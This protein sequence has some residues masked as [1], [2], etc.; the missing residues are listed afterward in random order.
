MK[1]ENDRELSPD[2]EDQGIEVTAR[3]RLIPMNPQNTSEVPKLLK[4]LM[5]SLDGDE[6]YVGLMEMGGEEVQY[7]VEV[8]SLEASASLEQQIAHIEQH[9]D[10]FEDH[11]GTRTSVRAYF[12]DYGHHDDLY[13]ALCGDLGI[14]PRY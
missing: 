9:A 13:E 6:V 12:A 11:V 4:E 7:L 3:L 5:G 2:D 10:K 8:R 14:E 1:L